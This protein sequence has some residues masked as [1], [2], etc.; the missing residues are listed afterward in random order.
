MYELIIWIQV[1]EINPSLSFFENML[2]WDTRMT[3]KIDLV[4]C[5]IW[6]LTTKQYNIYLH[7]KGQ[8]AQTPEMVV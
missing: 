3:P 8:W 1:M 2:L 5:G 4:L 6:E 7:K